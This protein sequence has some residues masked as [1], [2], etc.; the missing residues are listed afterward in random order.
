[1]TS[2]ELTGT[3]RWR[4]ADLT[5]G[6]GAVV[7]GIG[8]GS[9]FAKV[10]STASNDAATSAFL[11]AARLGVASTPWSHGTPLGNS[12]GAAACSWQDAWSARM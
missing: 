6:V 1:M 3:R 5:S 4:V 7:L 11:A 8:I 2:T 10:F 9:V 12:C